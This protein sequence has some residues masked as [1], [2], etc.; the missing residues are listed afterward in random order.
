MWQKLRKWFG[1]E[2]PDPFVRQ[3]FFESNIRS[4]L[5]MTVV[6]IVL[7]VWMIFNMLKMMITGNPPRTTTWFIQ[8][9][10]SYAT[11][12]VTGVALLIYAIRFI[13]G[14]NPSKTLGNAL[15]I[16]FSVV[17]ILFGVYI[18]YLDYVKGEQIL[19]FLMMIIY[20]CGL[21][22]W[23]PLASLLITSISFGGFYLLCNAAAPASY[24]TKVN[25]FT[26]W[27]AVFM[28][29]LSIFQQKR[30]E[31]E[32]EE[33]VEN[34]NLHLQE[35]SVKDELTGISNMH[36]FRLRSGQLLL[37]AEDISTKRF[38]FLDIENFKTLNEKYGFREGNNF[39][40]D[41]ASKLAEVFAGDPA[42]RISDDH[43]VVFTDVNAGMQEKLDTLRTYIRNEKP[44]LFLGLKCGA[45]IPTERL[46]SPSAA[47]DHARYACNSIKNEYDQN[48]REYDKE[49]HL[50]SHRKQYI[51]NHIDEAIV[52]GDI[53]V[54]YQPVVWSKD[55]KL[56]G[57]EALARWDDEKYG[58]LTP[59]A[60]VPILEEYRQIYKLDKKVVE[61]VCQDIR[62]T[63]D[64][65]LSMVPVSINFS[66]LDFELFDI[67]SYLEEQI[68]QYQIPKNYIHIEI[69]ESAL[70]DHK[71]MLKESIERLEEAGYL[72][73]LDDF[74]SGYSSLNVLKDYQFEVMKLDMGFLSG[75]SLNDRSRAI[76]DSVIKMADE[77]GMRTL[78]EGVETE[79]IAD[80]LQQ[81]GCERLQGYLFGR[82]QSSEDIAKQIQDGTYVISEEYMA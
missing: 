45:Y 47:C 71:G 23:H 32:K 5:Y 62:K 75:K 12:L 53:L 65:G 7:E 54:Y 9:G 10:I 28:V 25:L 69:T 29:S 21:Y 78:T 66:R 48:Y 37:D 77:I 27:I 35:M 14:K 81:T 79:E 44:E 24:A 74:G 51:V 2:K 56:C 4:S 52:N 8:H 33:K 15:I 72:L 34:M 50:E 30:R 59:S 60:F 40:Q 26:V 18:S 63:L 41:V 17:C 3:Y 64:A 13:R 42:A 67:I 68:E 38:L 58:F 49:L 20:V 22:V 76:I 19:A 11:L 80:F 31:A 73:W 43:F 55:H 16:I 61:V 36:D 39:L 1:L 6:V 46:Y 70:V 82:P 57:L